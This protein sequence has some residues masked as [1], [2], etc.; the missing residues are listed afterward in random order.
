MFALTVTINDELVHQ[1]TADSEEEIYRR[2]LDYRLPLG[3][4]RDGY[5]FLAPAPRSRNWTIRKGTGRKTIGF[6]TVR[7]Q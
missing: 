6:A 1:D 5:R 4:T 2:F 7:E 3:R